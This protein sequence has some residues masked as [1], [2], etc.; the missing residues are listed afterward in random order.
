MS[1]LK[2]NFSVSVSS[3]ILWGCG[4]TQPRSYR[5]LKMGATDYLL[6]TQHQGSD[7]ITK[8]MPE[9][10]TSAAPCSLRGMSWM[11]RPIPQVGI[12]K[13]H[14]SLYFSITGT[15]TRQHHS[16]IPMLTGWD[17]LDLMPSPAL[18]VGL[19]CKTGGDLV[20]EFIR[21]PV[22]SSDTYSIAGNTWLF[23]YFFTNK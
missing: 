22:S 5:R 13:V 16:R 19:P 11:C 15:N 20:W 8:M 21:I 3:L 12:N 9:H 18:Q 6:G 10:C 23:D 7:F 4:F 17:L 14:P 1:V 2:F